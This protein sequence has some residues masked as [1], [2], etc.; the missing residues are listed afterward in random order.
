MK[1]LIIIPAYNE[2]HGILNT[3]NDLKNNAKNV[4]YVVIND[5]SKDNTKKVLLEN[6]INFI[7]LTNNLG[8][9][10]A[11]QTGYKYALE[12]GY[13]VAIQF[14]GDNQHDAK[15]IEL[16]IKEIENGADLSIGSRYV[17]ELSE[18]KS[19]AMRRFGKN[20]LSV[21]I[22]ICTGTKI[23]DPT[24]GYRA[25]NAKVIKLFA[26]SYPTDYPEPDTVAM[27]LKKGYKVTEIP[28]KMNERKTGKSSI[29]AFKSIYY[30]IKVGISIILTSINTKREK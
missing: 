2:E 22:K 29:N 4:D 15:Y 1:T 20:I 25:A 17:S 11:V 18:F 10:G 7:D 14:D 8:I 3:I 19:T 23:Y 13:D 24:S 30:M 28:V 26:D 5:G 9:G 16:L 6:D 12:K 21:L 27:I